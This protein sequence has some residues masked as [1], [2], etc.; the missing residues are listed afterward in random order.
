MWLNNGHGKYE[1]LP[2]ERAFFNA[3]KTSHK[4]VCHFYLPSTER[5]KILHQHMQKIAPKYLETRFVCVNSEK[6]SDLS[7]FISN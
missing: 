6:V 4:V 7:F 5:C 3:V 2:D 1:E